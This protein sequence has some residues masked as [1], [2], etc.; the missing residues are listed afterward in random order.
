MCHALALKSVTS[1]KFYLT[2]GYYYLP[3]TGEGT[4]LERLCDSPKVHLIIGSLNHYAV[5]LTAN[6]QGIFF[7]HWGAA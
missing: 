1:L 2:H 4:S 7:L 6:A 3:F 5:S